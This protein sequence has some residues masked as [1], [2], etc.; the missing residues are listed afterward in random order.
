MS[1]Q[2]RAA[3]DGGV[4]WSELEVSWSVEFVLRIV[5]PLPPLSFTP[6][7][8]P[9]LPLP[10]QCFRS[11]SLDVGFVIFLIPCSVA[12]FTICILAVLLS[13]SL[14]LVPVLFEFSGSLP[15]AHALAL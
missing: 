14:T 4:F 9:S 5:A 15:V 10:F 6:P 12:L 2:V 1:L 11:L 13:S 3:A 7:P 8:L